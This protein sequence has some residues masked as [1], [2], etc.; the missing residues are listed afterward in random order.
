[1]AVLED[2][3]GFSVLLALCGNQDIAIDRKR[4]VQLWRDFS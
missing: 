1:M 4:D 2:R 3:M